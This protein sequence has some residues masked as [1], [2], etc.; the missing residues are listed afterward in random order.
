MTELRSN[1]YF[2]AIS[3]R[4]KSPFKNI[5]FIIRKSTTTINH[6]KKEKKTWCVKD[7]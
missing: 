6:I 1:I 3:I 2:I 5:W 7:I 4:L